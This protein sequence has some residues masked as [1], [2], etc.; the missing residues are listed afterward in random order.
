MAMEIEVGVFI[1]NNEKGLDIRY[2]QS[3]PPSLSSPDVP[4]KVCLHRMCGA[5]NKTDGR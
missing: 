4:L 5:P 2:C 3:S 1:R